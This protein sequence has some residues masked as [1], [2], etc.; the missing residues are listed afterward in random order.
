[1]IIPNGDLLSNRLVNWSSRGTYL[2]TDFTLKVSNDTNVDDLRTIIQEEASQLGESMQAP[3][4]IVSTISGDSIELKVII[5]IKSISSEASLKS[6]LL[7]RLVSRFK[8][9]DIKLL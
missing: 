9:A 1:V 5:W 3:D 2:K 7:Q 6:E 4:I 8:E